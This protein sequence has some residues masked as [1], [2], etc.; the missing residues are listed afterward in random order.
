[1]LFLLHDQLADVV[2]QG[3]EVDLFHV[4]FRFRNEEE[5]KS[6]ESIGS[7]NVVDWMNSTN[8]HREAKDVVERTLI[9]ELL[10]DACQFLFE[11]IECAAKGKISVAF[12]LLRK[13]LRDQLFMMEWML[14]DRDGFLLEFSKGPEQVDICDLL[15]KK[16]QWMRSIV[17]SALQLSAY[18][19]FT[20]HKFLWELRFE[21]SVHWSLE[22]DWNQALH[23][24]T[25][26]K[27]YRTDV[28]S[29][30]FAFITEES[31]EELQRRFYLLTTSVLIHFCGVVKAIIKRW[32]P[33]FISLGRLF[34][35][36][37]C[38]NLELSTRA[39]VDEEVDPFG[40]VAV[41]ELLEELGFECAECQK[42]LRIAGSGELEQFVI[43]VLVSCSHC[44]TVDNRLAIA[45]SMDDIENS[46]VDAPPMV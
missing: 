36:R 23:L 28:E 31:R 35:I 19:H 1:M 10:S 40:V 17:E 22:N 21:K 43:D 4:S 29:L 32:D 37:L 25:T 24:I 3:E 12:A 41:N 42:P 27:H 33:S 8:R 7:G 16:G 2:V 11:S 26:H 46:E 9:H 38:A 14:A 13:P 45:D 6:F 15:K 44:G 30:N 18:G 5:Q 20:D 39:M 34:G